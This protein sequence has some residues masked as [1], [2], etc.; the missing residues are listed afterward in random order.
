L[1]K[2]KVSIEG[3]LVYVYSED[4]SKCHDVFVR[5]KN[6]KGATCDMETGIR[7]CFSSNGRGKASVFAK[8]SSR[9]TKDDKSAETCVI[10]ILRSR[11]FSVEEEFIP[12]YDI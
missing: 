2:I 8:E 9:F 6:E 5:T 12:T 11:G 7:V 4:G 3:E 10:D 1:K